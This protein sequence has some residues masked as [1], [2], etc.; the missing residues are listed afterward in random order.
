M[1]TIELDAGIREVVG[2]LMENNI[3]TFSSC[4]GGEGHA[5]DMPTVRMN[6]KNAEEDAKHVAA[7][8]IKNGYSGFYVSIHWAYSST[9]VVPNETVSFI[10]VEFW[11][12]PI[13]KG[14]HEHL[15][16]LS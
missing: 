11:V 8:L 12:R 2:L 3:D 15:P 9:V 13:Q 6:F 5:F 7:I 16:S 10:Q 4:E 14:N 1:E